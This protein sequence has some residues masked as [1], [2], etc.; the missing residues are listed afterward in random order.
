MRIFQSV[1]GHSSE[2]NIRLATAHSQLYRSYK[3]S[4]TLHQSDLRIS[5]HRGHNFPPSLTL[6]SFKIRIEWPPVLIATANFPSLLFQLLQYPRQRPSYSAHRAALMTKTVSIFPAFSSRFVDFAVQSLLS[7]QVFIPRGAT[8]ESSLTVAWFSWTKQ[9]SFATHS[10]QWDCFI[11]ID[12]RLRQM[13]FFRV[14]AECGGKA[15]FRVMLKD[16]EIKK[17]FLW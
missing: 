3:V 2:Q 7:L 16:F 14:W 10:N 4:L 9:N 1:S 6:F 15:G 5:N 13:G 12:N 11:C 17:L 8:L